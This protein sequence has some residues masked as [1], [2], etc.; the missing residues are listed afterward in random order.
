MIQNFLTDI[1]KQELIVD[2]R[3]PLRIISTPVASME[4]KILVIFPLRIGKNNLVAIHLNNTVLSLLTII[5][6]PHPDHNLNV[7]SH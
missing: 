1:I 6:G 4:G 7:I 5:K 2:W 3:N